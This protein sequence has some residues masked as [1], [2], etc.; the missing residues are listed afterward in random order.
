MKHL[1]IIDAEYKNWISDI[2]K[3]FR[4]SQIKAATKVND[5]ML[6]FYWSIG[7][8]IDKRQAE[9]KW[10]DKL[11]PTMSYDL[12]R[13]LPDAHCFSRTNLYYIKKFYT[14]YNQLNTIIPQVGGQLDVAQIQQQ[15]FSIPWGH[16]KRII[17]KL[18]KLNNDVL[19][20]LFYVQKTIE[21]NLSRDVL[22]HLIDSDL[23]GREGRAITN[24]SNTLP[25][26]ESDL[27]QQITKDPYSFDFLTIAEPYREKE[28][29]DALILNI[30]RFLLEL[31]NG[32]AYLGREYRLMI[33]QT[34]KFIDML[35]YNLKLECYIVIEIK[36]RSF[37]PED[38]GQLSAYVAG[39]NHNLKRPTD[40]PTIGL[41]ICK[42]KDEILAKYTIENFSQPIGISEYELNN[43]LP[44][45][46][47][48]TLP[49][50]EEIEAELS[51]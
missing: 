44:D 38:V 48:G 9:S 29:K 7:E 40:K 18:G 46:F 26:E 49:T 41:L 11:I 37:K 47:K 50:I 35:F 45:N 51:E 16:H 5:E 19:S 23:I 43:L 34:E 36:T 4:R 31:G 20:A 14:L 13:E 30:E 24:F 42:D 10:G 8:D 15:I 27:A 39:V 12:K 3:R 32:F 28:L 33:G 22:E 2:C 25:V 21:Q 6:R 17:D 1:T